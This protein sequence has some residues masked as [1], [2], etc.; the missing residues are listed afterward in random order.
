MGYNIWQGFGNLGTEVCEVPQHAAQKAAW[1]AW[2]KSVHWKGA[3]SLALC[4]PL[5]DWPA[6]STSLLKLGRSW[7]ETIYPNPAPRE[8]EGRKALP[9]YMATTRRAGFQIPAFSSCGRGEQEPYFRFA[10]Q[11]C[12]GGRA[13]A[14][15]LL[16]PLLSVMSAGP[17]GHRQIS[18]CADHIL[19]RVY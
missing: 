10:Q 4:P 12:A 3:S 13:A 5:P 6:G 9:E 17:C 7:G 15:S 1:R 14:R 19:G 16:Q 11:L 2:M 18:V 8:Q